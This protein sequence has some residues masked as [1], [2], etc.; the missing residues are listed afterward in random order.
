MSNLTHSI[1]FKFWSALL[2]AALAVPLA[3]HAAKPRPPLQITIVPA[4]LGQLAEAIKPGEV[5]DLKIIGKT[6]V[7]ADE[8]S[9]KVKLHGGMELISGETTWVGPLKKGQEKVL[10][11]TVRV[12]KQGYGRIMARIATPPTAGA[13]FVAETEY[14]FGSS[15]AK[16]PAEL[17]A[18][19]KDS[20]G[21]EI[22]EYPG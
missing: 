13:S 19:K 3:V 7:D 17:P 6:F 20:K 12:P 11:L 8:L 5:V 10:V 14:Q 9:I 1:K 21:R 22:R 16:K 4:Q 2:A 18:I 15:A